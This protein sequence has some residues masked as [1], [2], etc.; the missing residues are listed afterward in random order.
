MPRRYGGG[1]TNIIQDDQWLS[2]ST[3][4][5]ANSVEKTVVDEDWSKL[6]NEESQKD[7][8]NC[9]EDK[10][11]DLEKSSQFRWLEAFHDLVTREND[12][13]VG[14]NESYRLLQ[15]R[16][17]RYS[18]YKLELICWVSDCELKGLVE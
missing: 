15:S 11:V 12:E 3:F 4:L 2:P 1:Y 18:L 13:V 6:L 9:G 10:V 5:V 17:G 8:R 14:S 16:H 7:G